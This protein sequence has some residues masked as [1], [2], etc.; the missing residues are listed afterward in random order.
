MSELDKTVKI[1]FWIDGEPRQYAQRL[2]YHV[3]RVGEF[4]VFKHKM[5]PVKDVIWCLDEDA[6]ARGVK[7]QV[8]LGDI[9]D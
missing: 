3:P 2:M 7:V 9:V 6:T 1:D 8:V 4:C 5:R